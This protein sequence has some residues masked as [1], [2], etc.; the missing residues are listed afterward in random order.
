MHPYG[1]I[2]CLLPKTYTSTYEFITNS[3]VSSLADGWTINAWPDVFLHIFT[4]KIQT[5][6]FCQKLC[7]VSLVIFLCVVYFPIFNISPQLSYC[8]CW[9]VYHKLVN[10]PLFQLVIKYL[11]IIILY[12][13]WI[14]FIHIIVQFTSCNPIWINTRRFINNAM[15]IW[16]ISADS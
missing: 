9:F 4:I 14:N 1:E 5:P 6:I 11:I 2:N 10:T 16:Y 3:I 12:T 13:S 7:R 8:W 15:F